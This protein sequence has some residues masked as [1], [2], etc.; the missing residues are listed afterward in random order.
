MNEKLNNEAFLE[1][2]YNGNKTPLTREEAISFAQKGMNYDKLF[3]KNERLEK[4]LKGLTLINEKIG[5]IA[6]ELKLSPTELLEGLEEERVREEIRAYSDENEIPYEYAEKLKSMEEKIKALENGKKELI[7]LKERKEEL[8]EFKKLYPDVDE[9]ELDPEILKAWEE[10]KRP[11]KDIYSEVTLRKLLKEKDAKSANE[12]NK[13]S[14]SGSA[15][16]TPEAE[17]EYT[18]EII[19]NMSDKEFNR[20]FSKILKQYKKGE[21]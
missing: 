2:V 13:N 4:E 8:S 20:N 10:G 7:P 6:A 14:S 21:R 1:V 19:R 9:R 5:K 3:E 11:L 15:L 17:E 16:G 12:E 18:D